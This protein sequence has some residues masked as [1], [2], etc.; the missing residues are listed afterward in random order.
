M[1]TKQL[2]LIQDK[3]LTIM[4]DIHHICVKNGLRYFLIGG[5]AI[6]AARHKGFIPWDVDIDIAMPREDYQAF[7]EVYSKQLL[8]HHRIL[9]PGNTP[10]F[11]SGHAIIELRDS[12]VYFK[13]DDLNPQI[14]NH[15]LYVDI[16]PLDHVP[17][18]TCHR[19]LQ[20]RLIRVLQLFKSIFLIKNRSTDGLIKRVLKRFLIPILSR[21]PISTVCLL[22]HRVTQFYNDDPDYSEVCSMHSHYGYDK[23]CM[24]KHLFETPVLA[25][26]CGRSYYVSSDNHQYLTRLFGDYNKLPSVEEQ[27][28]MMN[29]IKIVSWPGQLI[30]E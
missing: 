20:K 24:P 6:G 25:D 12:K 9:H 18:K 29:V 13:E 3:Q 23:L 30:S 17:V 8:P 14:V 2:K 4:D 11:R 7:I 16:L 27:N 15:G 21:G 1:T 5:S 19:N 28:A 26:F 22:T 10:H